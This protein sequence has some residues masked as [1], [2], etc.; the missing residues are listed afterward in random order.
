MG[1][2]YNILIELEVGQYSICQWR[3]FAKMILLQSHLSLQSTRDVIHACLAALVVKRF[4][5]PESQFCEA[6]TEKKPRPSLV[7]RVRPYLQM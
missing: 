2:R 6:H 4:Q 5:R 1:C 3:H 7:E